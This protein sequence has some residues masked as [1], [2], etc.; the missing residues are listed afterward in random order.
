MIVAV[1]VSS[2]WR[3]ALAAA[4]HTG[5]AEAVA[6]ARAAGLA[7]LAARLEVE[8]SDG[9][10]ESFLS[11]WSPDALD[12]EPFHPA[13]AGWSGVTGGWAH[14]VADARC[15]CRFRVLEVEDTGEWAWIRGH[16]G[17]VYRAEGAPP[18]FFDDQLLLVA[19]PSPG[20]GWRITRASRTPVR[21]PERRAETAPPPAPGV[22][23]STDLVYAS[24]GGFELSL[25]LYR[26]DGGPDRAPAI[27]LVPGDGW[28]GDVR[29]SL[30]ALAAGLAARGYVAATIEYRSAG[31]APFPAAVEDARAAVAWLRSRGPEVGADPD[32]VAIV[33]ASAGAWVAALVALTGRL[34]GEGPPPAGMPPATVRAAALLSPVVDLVSLGEGHPRP[35]SLQAALTRYLGAPYPEAPERWALAS[36]LSYVTPYAPPTLL[37]HGSEDALTPRSQSLDLL[38]RLAAAEVYADLLT[39]TGGDHGFYL[40]RRWHAVAVEKIDEFLRRVLS[41]ET[42]DYRPRRIR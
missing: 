10:L 17:G 31:E 24:P 18:V 36:P 32:R 30:D 34:E 7:R 13:R 39:A 11:L 15:S 22:E 20:E 9:T 6:E 8:L 4:Q 19:R 14:L 37:L 41:G 3:P 35:R 29:R 28:N 1:V 38:G 23:V 33:G 12:L 25:E 27:V 26:P 16:L 2:A 40:E 42:P 5:E 21:R